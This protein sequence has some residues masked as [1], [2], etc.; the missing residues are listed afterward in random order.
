MI[1]VAYAKASTGEESG[2]TEA[3]TTAAD[4]NSDGIVDAKDAS[5]VLAYYALVS[6]A[7][8]ISRH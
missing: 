6:T 7:E 3:E 1:L 5:C 2:L 8:G 4:I